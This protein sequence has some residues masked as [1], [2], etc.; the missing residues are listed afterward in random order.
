MV[1]FYSENIKGDS[2]LGF[3]DSYEDPGFEVSDLVAGENRKRCELWLKGKDRKFCFN[4][5]QYPKSY[6]FKFMKEWFY[7]IAGNWTIS[8]LLSLA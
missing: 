3:D 6:I 7:R 4:C 8:K 5:H 2:G 1:I